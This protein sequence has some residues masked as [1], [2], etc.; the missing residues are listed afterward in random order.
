MSLTVTDP[1]P[2]I[3]VTINFSLLQNC[4]A[5]ESLW[6]GEPIPPEQQHLFGDKQWFSRV[7]AIYDQRVDGTVAWQCPDCNTCWDRETGKRRDGFNLDRLKRDNWRN[8]AK[9]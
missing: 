6:Q 1:S 2:A 5:C 3:P 9:E 7:F 8:G 4:P